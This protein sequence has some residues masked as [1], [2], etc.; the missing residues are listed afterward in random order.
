MSIY[1]FS[2]EIF[3]SSI[4]IIASPTKSKMQNEESQFVAFDPT[5]CRADALKR[6]AEIVQCDR[7]GVSG[8]RPNMMRWHFENCKVQLK[9][10]QHCGLNIPR[11]GVKD[12]I[13]NRKKFCGVDCY[14]ESKKGKCPVN[15]TEDV[16]NKISDNAKRNWKNGIYKDRKP[17]RSV[18]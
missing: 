18:R 9:P 17:K 11:Q 12:F 14:N 13:Y 7:C 16:R 15:M 2:E 10:C 6:N 4:G 5:I 3:A 1:V 8:N